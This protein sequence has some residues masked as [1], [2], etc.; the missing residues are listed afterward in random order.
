MRSGAGRGF[1][2][3]W[4]KKFLLCTFA[5]HGPGVPPIIKIIA[6]MESSD[7]LR[8][9]LYT[10]FLSGMDYVKSYG[11]SKLRKSSVVK[12]Q[13]SLKFAVVTK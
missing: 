11:S 8:S 1:V 12:E 6:E 7:D 9:E 4:K 3:P 13:C 2:D 5:F 10:T